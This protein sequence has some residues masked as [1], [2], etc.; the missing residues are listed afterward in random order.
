MSAAETTD[1]TTSYYSWL[2]QDRRNRELQFQLTCWIAK[3]R[4][5]HSYVRIEALTEMLAFMRTMTEEDQEA[6]IRLQNSMDENLAYQI[7]NNVLDPKANQ[8]PPHKSKESEARVISTSEIVDALEVVQGCCL[9]HYPS[10]QLIGVECQGVKV[11]LEHVTS[12]QSVHVQLSALD[13][14]LALMVDAEEV[15]QLFHA[16]QG[17]KAL[18]ELL[19]HKS[20]R[21]EVRHKLS[22]VLLFMIRYFT[23]LRE[24]NKQR[25]Q[26]LLGEKLTNALLQSVQLTN[27]STE[28]R[29]DAFIKQLDQAR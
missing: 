24:E 14:L 5:K 27:S 9:L 25:V 11:L 2:N 21:S 29:F 13:T 26:S 4:T 12:A 8:P 23:E 6:F 3:L 19:K 10:K 18:I 1:F 16:Q 28:E 22:A 17:L 7:W 20:T 15:Q